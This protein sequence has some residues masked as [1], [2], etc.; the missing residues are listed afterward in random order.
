MDQNESYKC[1]C[2]LFGLAHALYQ[3]LSATV[4][5]CYVCFPSLCLHLYVQVVDN[6]VGI[7]ADDLNIVGQRYAT[8]K[9]HTLD[10]LSKREFFG[11]HGEA[12][13]SIISMSSHVEISSKH[14]VCAQTHSKVFCKG[15]SMRVERSIQ[16]R[17]GSGTTVTVQGFMYNT[18]VRREA[19]SSVLEIER[20]KKLI[21]YI[22]LVNS[23][24]SLCAYDD[25]EGICIINVPKSKSIVTNFGYLFGSERATHLKKVSATLNQITI[26]GYISV[27]GYHD[28]TLQFVYV[29][30]RIVGNCTLHTHINNVLSKSMFSAKV[31]EKPGMADGYQQHPM[32]WHNKHG[33]YIVCVHCSRDIYCMSPESSAMLVEFQDWNKIIAVVKIMLKKFLK[34]CCIT[35][36]AGISSHLDR[37]SDALDCSRSLGSH[38]AEGQLLNVYKK[39]TIA[40]GHDSTSR[41]ASNEPVHVNTENILSFSLSKAKPPGISQAHSTSVCV[42]SGAVGTTISPLLCPS[43]YPIFQSLKRPISSKLDHP[44]EDKCSST[45]ISTMP[46]VQNTNVLTNSS[47]VRSIETQLLQQPAYDCS[48]LEGGKA[49]VLN[50]SDLFLGH[51]SNV[52]EIASCLPD[53]ITITTMAPISLNFCAASLSHT[54]STSITSLTPVPI[55]YTEPWNTPVCS[56]SVDSSSSDVHEQPL[57]VK[58]CHAAVNMGFDI[59]CDVAA[60]TD[61]SSRKGVNFS[62]SCAGDS[63]LSIHHCLPKPLTGVSLQNSQCRALTRRTLH[64]H[65]LSGRCSYTAPPPMKDAV[66]VDRDQPGGSRQFTEKHDRNSVARVVNATTNKGSEGY[67]SQ[68]HNSLPSGTDI[69]RTNCYKRNPR[70]GIAPS[71]KNLLAAGS[72]FPQLHSRLGSIHSSAHIGGLDHF[73]GTK[74]KSR[75]VLGSQGEL[76][77]PCRLKSDLACSSLPKCIEKWNNPV[78]KPG[79]KVNI[80]KNS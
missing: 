76:P 7:T 31:F 21:R 27:E 73:S 6:G 44:H 25:N 12:L 42:S 50:K 48:S 19:I 4:S 71:Q 59:V 18:P 11:F 65:P 69:C 77:Q 58:Q 68:S 15:K 45:V 62:S 32:Y 35:S 56:S 24:C 61:T 22:A 46:N 28:K 67:L 54:A 14:K 20:I 49:A 40:L 43:S 2:L 16:K 74:L 41:A 63:A 38:C 9:C 79:D 55:R 51:R 30:G 64:V 53:A 60:Q 37:I 8:S 23:L 13:A 5:S 78:F 10:D 36:K 39:G 72:A 34:N 66:Q 17:R 29:N 70:K 33:I 52:T 47:K 80:S 75:V 57:E 1:L 26:D 3:S